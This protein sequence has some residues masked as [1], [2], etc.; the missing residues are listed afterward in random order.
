MRHVPHSKEVSVSKPPENLTLRALLLRKITDN[1]RTIFNA[2][3]Y[4]KQV[5]PH[6]N[7]FIK[8]RS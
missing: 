4:L 6:L 5:V 8:T 3:Q 2:I 7:P 1:M